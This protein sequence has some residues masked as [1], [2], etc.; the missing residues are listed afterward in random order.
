MGGPK[1]VPRSPP[2]KHTTV[3]ALSSQLSVF[4]KLC[5]PII[6]TLLHFL[7]LLCKSCCTRRN[8]SFGGCILGL[9]SSVYHGWLSIMTS[10]ERPHF[11][12]A[13]G[14]PITNPTLGW[15]HIKV[16]RQQVGIA[17]TSSFSG[18]ITINKLQSY[19]NES[20]TLYPIQKMLG[21]W[22][23]EFVHIH[24]FMRIHEL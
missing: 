24:A 17:A 18:P 12:L 5:R 15:Q 20:F 14:P 3:P 7:L 19:P 23:P 16:K 13:F 8:V 11:S 9:I 10:S 1:Q 21:I 2:L 6:N 22:H 4:L